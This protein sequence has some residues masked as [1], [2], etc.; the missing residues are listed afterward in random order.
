MTSLTLAHSDDLAQRLRPLE[1]FLSTVLE[2][3]L[4]G[5]QT[6]ASA[7]ATEVIQFLSG[8]PSPKEI[9]AY[10]ASERTQ[11]RTRRLLA[12]NQAGLLSVEEQRKLDEL[13]KIEHLVRLLKAQ[14]AVALRD[15]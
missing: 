5:F 9:L 4:V 3:S 10:H 6:A 1:P 12:L 2:L 8:D 11:E 15:A 14:A 13:E 7:T